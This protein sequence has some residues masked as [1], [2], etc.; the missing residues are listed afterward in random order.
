MDKKVENICIKLFYLIIIFFFSL[1]VVIIVSDT[2]YKIINKS[3]TLIYFYHCLG[4]YGNISSII[5][6]TMGIFFLIFTNPKDLF[7]NINKFIYKLMIIA[8]TVLAIVAIFSENIKFYRSNI[9]ISSLFNIKGTSY[10]YNDITKVS[11]YVSR[12]H[13]ELY[14]ELYMKDN[15]L[16]DIEVSDKNLDYIY[17]IENCIPYN[18]P[19]TMTY[20][21]YERLQRKNIFSPTLNE[22][23]CLKFKKIN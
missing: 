15:C 17:I 8:F 10:S 1:I 5:I 12:K 3:S 11:T 4:D 21:A 22:N 2:Q 23:F 16:M 6:L 14:Y 18:I 19:H 13:K 20:D 9:V 7:L